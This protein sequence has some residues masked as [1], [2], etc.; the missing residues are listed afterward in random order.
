MVPNNI[1][2]NVLIVGLTNSGKTQFLVDQLCALCGRS[3]YV[4][5]QMCPKKCSKKS[6]VFLSLYRLYSF[7]MAG[8]KASEHFEAKEKTLNPLLLHSTLRCAT[9]RYSALLCATLRYST[10]LY[11]TLFYS[12]LLYSTLLYA[13]LLYATLLYTTPL[14]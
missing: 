7:H 8:K 11:S 5:L 9:L 2:F 1:P 10:L 13:T 14:Y 12:T 6:A 4:V 3:H